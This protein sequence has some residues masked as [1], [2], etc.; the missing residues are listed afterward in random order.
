[1]SLGHDLAGMA[2]R[3]KGA[4]EDLHAAVTVEVNGVVPILTENLVAVLI[5]PPRIRWETYHSEDMDWT[6]FVI[7]P[8]AE[9]TTAALTQLSDVL[10]ALRAHDVLD[11]HEAEPTAWDTEGR[12]FNGYM[13]RF[14]T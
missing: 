12:T 4:V 9:D 14:T 7:S 5:L 11:L 6:A 1:M 8:L 2:A 3:A 10:D 13:A